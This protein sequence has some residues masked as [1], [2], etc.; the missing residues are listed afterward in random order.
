MTRTK[1]KTIQADLDKLIKHWPGHYIVGSKPY[2][3]GCRIYLSYNDQLMDYFKSNDEAFS[4]MV[5]HLTGKTPWWPGKK[6]DQVCDFFDSKITVQP[7]ILVSQA[8]AKK[9]LNLRD[10][11]DRLMKTIAI[12]PLDSDWRNKI[13]TII[14]TVSA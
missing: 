8:T 6:K 10:E 11:S 1:N 14:K 9:I 13:L 3:K 12:D 5:G 7:N 4:T 2:Q